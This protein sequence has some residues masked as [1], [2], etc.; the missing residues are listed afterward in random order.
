LFSHVYFSSGLLTFGVALCH[1]EG[2][3]IKKKTNYQKAALKRTRAAALKANAALQRTAR[4]EN[5]N[6][7]AARSVRKTANG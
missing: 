1:A 3:A 6:R 2:M 7:P 5:E 4:R